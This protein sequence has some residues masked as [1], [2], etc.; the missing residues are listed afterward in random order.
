MDYSRLGLAGSGTQVT[1][2][3]ENTHVEHIPLSLRRAVFGR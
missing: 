2:V 1:I 3:I